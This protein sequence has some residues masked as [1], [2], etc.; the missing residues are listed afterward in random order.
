[1]VMAT[2]LIIFL[3]RKEIAQPFIV[4]YRQSWY[5]PINKF[6]GG[7]FLRYAEALFLL[8]KNKLLQP[9]QSL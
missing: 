6:D 9:L 4:R 7:H 1:M 3:Y 5:E 8:K 2:G